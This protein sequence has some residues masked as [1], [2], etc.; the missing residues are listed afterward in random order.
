M[1]SN[2]MRIF[3]DTDILLDILLNRQPHYEA[4]AG[5]L[6]WGLSTR[7]REPSPGMGPPTFI[8]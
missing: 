1:P 3:L 8:I 5:V 6:D 7:D 2:A 4:S